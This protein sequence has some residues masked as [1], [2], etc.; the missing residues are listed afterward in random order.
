VTV[1]AEVVGDLALQ[2]GLEQPLREPREH[3]AFPGQVQPA[4]PGPPGQLRDQLLAH[5]SQ[6][7][8]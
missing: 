4:N 2:R 8:H 3:A 1:V 7:R 5:H 6:T